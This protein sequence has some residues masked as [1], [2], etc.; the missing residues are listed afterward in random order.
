MRTSTAA[1]LVLLAAVL[2]VAAMA[3]QYLLQ[4]MGWSI[5]YQLVL[6]TPYALTLL[7][8]AGFAGRAASPAALG[9]TEPDER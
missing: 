3:L 2:F 5:P 9:R 8:L 1:G 7:A 4:A 6:A